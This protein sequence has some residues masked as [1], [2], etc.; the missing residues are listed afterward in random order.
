VVMEVLGSEERKFREL[1]RRGRSLL[2]RLYPTGQ[3]TPDDYEYLRDTHG[4]PG[5][6]VTD[7]LAELA[8]RS[9]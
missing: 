1:L 2:P 8:E 7:L 6:L 3:L 5:E 4:L 9:G